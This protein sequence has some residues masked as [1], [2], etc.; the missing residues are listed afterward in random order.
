METQG[1][2]Q[3]WLNLVL[4]I[5]LLFTPFFYQLSTLNAAA[6]N[7]YLLG[8]AVAVFAAWALA[9]PLRWPEAVNLVLGVWLLF[10]PWLLGFTDVAASAWNS[11]VVGAIVAVDAIWAIA[12]ERMMPR[13]TPGHSH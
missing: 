10:A 5:W 1:R 6:W 11:W 4:G 7:A 12:A 13:P 8:T 2:W 9:Q 3:D